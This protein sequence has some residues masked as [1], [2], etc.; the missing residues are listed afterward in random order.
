MSASAAQFQFAAEFVTFLAAAAGVALVLL[1]GELLARTP[2]ARAF[3]GL[4]FVSLMGGA[5]VHGA[6]VIEEADD[7]ALLGLRA[8]G[9]LAVGF[10]TAT[11]TGGRTA[12][13]FMWGGLAL[14]AMSVALDLVT[15]G[16]SPPLLLMVGGAGLGAALLTAS[17][18]SIA[19]RVAASAAGALLLVVLVLSVALSAVL[20]NTVEDQELTRLDARA[21]S[22]ATFAQRGETAA[23][24]A[25][26][27][28]VAANL[29]G[30]RA[31]VLMDL[32]A[33][34][35][36]NINDDL[37]FL[38]GTYFLG[39][40]LAFVAPGGRVLGATGFDA[41]TAVALAGSEVVRQA[42]Q[43]QQPR[44]SVDVVAG[45]ALAVAASPARVSVV[46]GAPVFLGVAVAVSQ[47]DDDYLNV[48]SSDD[49]TL[50][51]AF[52]DTS[53]LLATFGPQ[54]DRSVV[55]PLAREVI[56]TGRSRTVDT[57]DRFV[58]VRPVRSA[59]ERPVVAL[60]ASTPTT[61]VSESR[62]S[63]F[64]TL[65]VIALGGT[66]L[67]LLIAS[68]VGERIGAGLRRLTSAAEGIRRGDFAVRAGFGGEDEVGVLSAAFDSMAGSIQEKTETESRLRN[69]L[70]AVRR[71]QNAGWL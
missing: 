31:Q 12:R 66:V 60:I 39:T 51:L 42:T 20:A 56:A 2:S 30:Q 8:G 46:G 15:G 9:V 19:A 45:R 62:D 65:F 32:G 64:R 41:A 54:P 68:I 53:G 47:L 71:A 3:L 10:G 43:T 17:R 14:V 40:P 26:A 27:K 1:R 13:A 59:D 63:L 28:V 58:A 55:L 5:F 11:W 50:S 23:R 37:A 6:R 22:E 18:R 61:V 25:E 67:A 29:A 49:D 4:G 70:E 7:P 24:L 33:G 57:P 34:A 35:E 16:D 36:G 21:R 38:S 48:H 69:R 52:A 44:A